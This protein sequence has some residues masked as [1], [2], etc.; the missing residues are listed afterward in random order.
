MS[1][2]ELHADALTVLQRWHPADP[3]QES[4]RQA[5]I[6]YLLGMPDAMARSCAPGHLTASAVVIDPS[7]A[8]TLLTLHPRIGRWVQLGGHCEP[9]DDGLRAAAEREARE[10]SGIEDLRVSALPLQLDV[11]PLTCSGGVPTR[12]LDVRYLVVTSPGAEPVISD[13]SD[14]LLWFEF[15]RLPSGLDASTL[16]LIDAARRAIG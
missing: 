14:D 11:H 13:E 10:E 15:D 3:A 4:L 7:R 6:S 8:A 5:Y 1:F 12:H 9:D 2:A 16:A